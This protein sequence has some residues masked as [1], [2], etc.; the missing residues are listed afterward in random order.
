MRRVLQWVIFLALSA[1]FGHGLAAD[2]LK[3]F[4]PAENGMVRYVLQVPAREEEP[5]HRLELLVGK[6]LMLDEHNIYRLEGKI[7]EKPIEGWAYIRYVVERVGPLLGTRM[8]AVADAPQVERFVAIGGTPYLI[9]YNSRVPVVVYVPDGVE[10]RYR[11][12][13]GATKI[14][15]MAEG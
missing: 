6:T 11:L 12:W 15:A 14:K 13:S 8:A 10:V 5:L 3:A 4:P 1:V 7:V 2:N 9:P